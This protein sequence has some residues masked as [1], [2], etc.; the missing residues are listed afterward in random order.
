E[1]WGRSSGWKSEGGVGGER[2]Q[3][4]FGPGRFS[5]KKVSGQRDTSISQSLAGPPARNPCTLLLYSPG[6]P[7]VGFCSLSPGL[8]RGGRGVHHGPSAAATRTF[9]RWCGRRDT[10]QFGRAPV[11]CCA[12]G[13]TGVHPSHSTQHATLCSPYTMRRFIQAL[14]RPVKAWGDQGYRCGSSR[15]WGSLR[16]AG[17]AVVLYDLNAALAVLEAPRSLLLLPC[18]DAGL[19]MFTSCAIVRCRVAF[20]VVFTRHC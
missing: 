8:R 7:P 17:D 18:A 6:S 3:Q 14:L 20:V 12:V 16:G 15:R 4:G 2:L 9:W 1:L 5:G 19:F 10:A 11:R 13:P